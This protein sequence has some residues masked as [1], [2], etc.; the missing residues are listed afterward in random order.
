MAPPERTA[1]STAV[2]AKGERKSDHGSGQGVQPKGRVL[3]G[4]TRLDAADGVIQVRLPGKLADE[5]VDP[6]EDHLSAPQVA[7]SLDPQPQGLDPGQQRRR[8]QVDKVARQVE[9]KPAI[10]EGPGLKAG[11]IGHGD[12]KRPPGGQE[13]C[14]MAH[15]P[16]RLAKVLERM[17]ENDR[18][19]V[20][21]YL[22]DLGVSDVRSG[23]TRFEA[24]GFPAVAH[25]GLDEGS[26]AGSPA[27]NRAGRQDPV[28]AIGE[29]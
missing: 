24:D 16:G 27:E 6:A 4:L 11:R 19:P 20:P 10:A 18:R 1:T 8:A 28:Q 13:C 21:I 29:R 17:P 26:V 7:D 15:P 23:C 22:F 9:G 25:E 14:R 2:A 5:A 3:G 12:D